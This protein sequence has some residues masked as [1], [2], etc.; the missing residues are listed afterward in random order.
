MCTFD[1]GVAARMASLYGGTFF[2][3]N[4]ITRFNDGFQI[5]GRPE[6]GIVTRTTTGARGAVTFVDLTQRKIIAEGG[7]SE[8]R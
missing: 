8:R 6:T 5:Y 4:A 7:G 3:H 2:G 1:R